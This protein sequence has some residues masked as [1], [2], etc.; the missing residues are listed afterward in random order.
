ME[1]PSPL[2]TVLLVERDADVRAVIREAL[3]SQG[4]ELIATP[5]ATGA[6]PVLAHV[7][8]LGLIL[9]ERQ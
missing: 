6:L 7:E 2:R 5:N 9:L 4:Y 1:S 8:S 3:R